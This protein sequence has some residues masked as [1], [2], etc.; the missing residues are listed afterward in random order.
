V[1]VYDYSFKPHPSPGVLGD[2]GV[3]RYLAHDNPLTH[4]KI[5]RSDELDALHAQGLK[6][7]LIWEHGAGMDTWD[8]REAN[9]LADG[10]GVPEW[11]PIYYAIDQPPGSFASVGAALDAL[12]GP[13]PKGLY[14]GGP[15]VKWAL[16]TGHAQFGWIANAASWSGI[17]THGKSFAQVRTEMRATAPNAHLLQIRHGDGDDD[18]PS[19]TDVDVSMRP[20]WGGWHPTMSKPT[21][22]EA[23][24][25]NAGTMVT[26]QDPAHPHHGEIWYVFQGTSLANWVSS[27]DMVAIYRFT[28]VAG[29]IEITSEWFN[30]LTLLPHGPL[31]APFHRGEVPVG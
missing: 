11:V 7:G 24:P 22:E 12:P 30:N 25:V 5:L 20:F 29:P 2:E 15:V 16:D 19:G 9:R 23:E 4:D 1:P 27:P 26:P 13:R 28:G 8:G 17:D 3:M 14:A 21:A 31:T 6:V 10:L 18:R